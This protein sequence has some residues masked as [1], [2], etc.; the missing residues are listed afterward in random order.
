[1]KKL[2]SLI[3]I[4]L[5]CSFPVIQAQNSPPTTIDLSY[6]ILGGCVIEL[7]SSSLT[8]TVI[9]LPI[10][11]DDWVSAD[12][13]I[14]IDMAWKLD[15]THEAILKVETG[16]FLR[17]SDSKVMAPE[18]FFQAIY[19]GDIVGIF[20]L[21]ATADPPQLIWESNDPGNRAS[22]SLDVQFWNA[23]NIGSPGDWTGSY[24]LTLYDEVDI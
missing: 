13:L 20:P 6:T 17:T 1:M 23:I 5:L 2:F 3:V 18:V 11:A 16:D 7:S 14:T 10:I 8:W 15:N 12:A 9:E 21:P 19:T 4:L 24:I 22:A